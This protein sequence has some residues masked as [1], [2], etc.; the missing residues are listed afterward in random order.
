MNSKQ[1]SS[2][3]KYEDWNILCVVLD[4]NFFFEN[5]IYRLGLGVKLERSG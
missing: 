3:S 2:D 4:D 1:I 5:L